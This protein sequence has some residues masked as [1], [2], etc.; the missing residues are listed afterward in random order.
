MSEYEYDYE[1]AAQYTKQ[2]VQLA[3][4]LWG[5]VPL[6][7]QTHT[8]GDGTVSIQVYHRFSSSENPDPSNMVELEL[9]FQETGFHS[10]KDDY[11]VREVVKRDGTVLF[12]RNFTL[13]DNE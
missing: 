5:D 10:L 9:N 4:D 7:P 2:L 6:Q 13:E 11:T 3:Q 12:S 1:K 8:W